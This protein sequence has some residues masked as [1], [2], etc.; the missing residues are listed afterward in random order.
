MSDNHQIDTDPRPEDSDFIGGHTEE[1]GNETP[2]VSRD[3]E[4]EDDDTTHLTEYEN[5]LEPCRHTMSPSPMADPSANLTPP[6]EDI[7]HE[8][9]APSP[10]NSTLQYH[11]EAELALE[12]HP[13]VTR[14]PGCMAGTAHSKANLGKNQKYSMSISEESQENLYAPFVLKLEWEV[15][16]WAKLCGPSLTSFTELMAIE[17]VS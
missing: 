16:R 13:F 4:D 1:A 5:R 2:D 12:K 8:D 3:G 7:C 9:K 10:D 6:D 14:Y 11:R 17:G 15:A